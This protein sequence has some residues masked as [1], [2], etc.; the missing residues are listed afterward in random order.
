M[1]RLPLSGNAKGRFDAALC[2]C[3]IDLICAIRFDAILLVQYL[4]G[5]HYELYRMDEI[6]RVV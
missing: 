3:T 2:I 6:N 1:I 4:L 5:K